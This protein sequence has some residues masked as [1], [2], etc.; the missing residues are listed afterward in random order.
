M[1][2]G[3]SGCGGVRAA[4]KGMRIGVADNWVRHVR[5]VIDRHQRWL[6][7]VPENH[8]V[9]AACELNVLEQALNVCK[10]T[11]VQDAWLRGQQVEVHG[12]VYGLHN[13]ILE[14]LRLNVSRTNDIEPAYAR[15]VKLHKNRYAQRVG[16]PPPGPSVPTIAIN[17]SATS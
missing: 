16:S 5:D 8:R 12:W 14:D 17:N 10:S 1:I 15:A 2:V 13:G 3:H 6:K 7:Q 11:V 9:D 4:L